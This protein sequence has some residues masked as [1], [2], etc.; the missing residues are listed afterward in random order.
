MG[1]EGEE[2][3]NTESFQGQEHQIEIS[4]CWT[5][6]WFQ[7]IQNGEHCLGSKLGNEPVHRVTP[8]PLQEKHIITVAGFEF[9]VWPLD[10]LISRLE[11]SHRFSPSK[12]TRVREP[13]PVSSSVVEKWSISLSC[14]TGFVSKEPA[15]CL[16]LEA[17]PCI[18]RT[19]KGA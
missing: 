8:S 7:M 17:C 9:I 15:V 4:L 5:N 3:N 16:A 6:L 18:I 12:Y 19:Q 10:F 2:R 11:S 14:S 13:W 1:K